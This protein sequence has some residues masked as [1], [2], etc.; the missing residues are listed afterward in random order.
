[1]R[2]AVPLTAAVLA[3]APAAGA[4]LA[5]GFLE[6]SSPY[7]VAE[8]VERLENAIDEGGAKVVAKVD[9]A[10]AAKGA[11]MELRPTTL[12]IFGNPKMGTP[13]M[14]QAQS[15]ALDLPLRIAVYEDAEGKTVLVYQDLASL[16]QQHG[17]PDGVE[18]VEAAA[19]ALEA[20]TDKAVRESSHAAARSSSRRASAGSIRPS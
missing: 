3:T 13:L 18:Q 5:D 19:R 15:M 7:T 14:R 17:I 11:D 6:K 2:L 20:L 16:A 12:I 10:A 8:T 4:A 9:H 1:M